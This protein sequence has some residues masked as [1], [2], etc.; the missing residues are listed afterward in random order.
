MNAAIH[1][2]LLS[3]LHYV[4]R[5]TRHSTLLPWPRTVSDGINTQ[6][7]APDDKQMNP[8]TPNP[9]T[10]N[11][12]AIFVS[13]HF[14]DIAL[15]CGGTAA[16][17]ARMGARCIGLT[18]CAA[19]A[20]D[21]AGLS[22]YAQWLH[23]QWEAAGSAGTTP[24]NDVRREEEM[25][26]LRLLGLEPTWL[27][28]PDAP[29][30]RSSTGDP[31]YTSDEELFGHVALE[32]RRALVPCIANEIRRV[33]REKGGERGRVRVFAPLGVGHH[34]DHQLVHWAARR[35]GPRFGVLYYEDYPYAGKEDAVMRRLVELNS[36][37]QPRLTPISDLIGVKIAAIS[38]YKTQ[39]EVL[40][41]S[42]EAMPAAVR[43]YSAQVSVGEGGMQYGE[44]MWQ[45]HAPY[46]IGIV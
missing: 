29:Y 20:Q 43:S 44:R 37:A 12:L 31:F 26:A 21:E 8:R 35:L 27:D 10:K 33:A 30:R 23:G 14:D 15:S 39:L 38:R 25:A 7:T 13:P 16:R 41:G 28:V 17:L 9:Q 22:S 34:V 40:F 19:P 3:E 46:S 18:I 24:V 5:V 6:H 42:P 2:S 32:E 36:P 11:T 1:W 4:L 45:I